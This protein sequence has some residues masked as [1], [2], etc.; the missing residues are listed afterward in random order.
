MCIRDSSDDEDLLGAVEAQA[1]ADGTP[2]RA[3]GEPALHAQALEGVA[4][5]DAG[6]DEQEHEGEEPERHVPGRGQS[7][8]E[9][10]T[11]DGARDGEDD[12]DT[13]DGTG[14]DRPRAH[15]LLLAD[16]DEERSSTRVA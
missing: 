14:H 12:Q 1:R 3:V 5:D 4:E 6:D 8:P 9:G 15:P 7:D 2:D 10:Q 16:D 13:G 11:T